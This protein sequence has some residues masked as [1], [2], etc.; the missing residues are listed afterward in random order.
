MSYTLL[1]EKAR[2]DFTKEAEQSA[3]LVDNYVSLF[4][5]STQSDA[6]QLAK[7][8]LVK[9]A[10]GKLQTFY[11]AKEDSASS[12]EAT[13][14]DQKKISS[15]FS[16]IRKTHSSYGIVFLGMAD[17]GYIQEPDDRVGAGY[18]PR[19]RPWMMEALAETAPAS[20]SSAYMSTL[21]YPV[22]SAIAKVLDDSG[23]AIGVA[24]I[25]L[26]LSMLVDVMDTIKLGRTGR[27][28]LLEQNGT[29]LAYP[30]NK[31]ITMKRLGNTSVAGLD[32]LSDKGDG[33]YEV[34][35][36]D[37]SKL[38]Y[39]HNIKAF[40]YKLIILKDMGEVL[41][42]ADQTAQSICI[43]GS[44]ITIILGLLGYLLAR[45][46]VAPLNVMVQRANAIKNGEYGNPPSTELFSGELLEL[47]TALRAMVM[48]L[49]E[50]LEMAEQ[51]SREA[52]EQTSRATEALEAVEKAQRETEIARR[53]GIMQ[54]A[55]QLEAVV[56]GVSAASSELAEQ[57][58][59]TRIGTENQAARTGETATAMEEMNVAVV[60]VA[61]SASDAATHS[62]NAREQAEK[63]SETV[64]NV[65]SAINDVAER[66]AVMKSRLGTLGEQ[67]VGIGKIMTVITDI[68]DQTNLLA[69]NAAIEAARAGDAGRG[70]AVVADEVRKLAEKTMQATNEVGDAVS[71]IQNGTRDNIEAMDQATEAV[72]R[73]TAL[74]S[75][76]GTVL[77]SMMNLIEGSADMARTIATASEQQSAT[78]EEINQAV[79][80]V[81]RLAEN[82]A[83]SATA[84]VRTMSHMEK[85]TND[86]RRIINEL[87]Q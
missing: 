77:D 29:I 34:T 76:A 7:T 67:A 31:D 72:D 58:D 33:I 36:G 8:P 46:I 57:I 82:M 65:I 87:Q 6:E 24:A 17:G 4:M 27:V 26:E 41:E 74:A 71:A 40:K 59:Q 70:F 61:R 23:K 30:G 12:Q 32:S 83:S 43:V 81:S 51:K 68:A 21:G 22:A 44:I 66:S 84:S 15:L 5:K 45:S 9:Q 39:V 53:E 25:D 60:E 38:A 13:N 3:Q 78:S 80:E 86:L 55:Q 52:E 1:Y 20:V 49:V 73:S 35:I 79:E 18:D 16:N 54:A 10:I 47:N 14:P 64:K 19:K 75:D 28:A 69:L 63:G 85:L 56:A 42:S 37:V 62:D 11:N 50:A 2:E 48:S